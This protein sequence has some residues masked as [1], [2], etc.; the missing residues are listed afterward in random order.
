V[1][2]TKAAP[3]KKNQHGKQQGQNGQCHATPDSKA[4]PPN[5]TR[6]S[7]STANSKNKNIGALPEANDAQA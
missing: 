4:T 7:S 2:Y 6:A 5:S 1:R 3:H